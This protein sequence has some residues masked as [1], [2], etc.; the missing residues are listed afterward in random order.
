MVR[1][2]FVVWSLD[3]GRRA[4]ALGFLPWLAPFFLRARRLR[5][6]LLMGTPQEKGDARVGVQPEDL[7]P[8]SH[9][10]QS[11]VRSTRSISIRTC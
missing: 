10:P 8:V 11:T 6:R 9:A 3:A 4:Q 1:A 7:A 5:A 2:F